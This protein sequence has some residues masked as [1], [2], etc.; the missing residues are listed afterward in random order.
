MPM[1]RTLITSLITVLLVGCAHG[2]GILPA[3]PDT[4]M[5][6]EHYAPV[7]GGVTTAQQVAMTEANDFCENQGKKLLP[8]N[9]NESGIGINQAAWGNTGFSMTFRCL[10]PDDPELKRPQF[11]RSPNVV[12]EN[13]SR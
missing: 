9:T 10:S 1:R 3:G 8:L 12:I 13:R 4:Y 6:S 2:T 5:V 11:E 7:R